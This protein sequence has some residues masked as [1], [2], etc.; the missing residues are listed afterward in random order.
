MHMSFAFA[1]SLGAP[2]SGQ[3]FRRTEL[4][5]SVLK[6]GKEPRVC[7]QERVRADETDATMTAAVR[8]RPRHLGL[9]AL[10]GR[11]SHRWRRTPVAPRIRVRATLRRDQVVHG[12]ALRDRS[13]AEPVQCSETKVPWIDSGPGCWS[14]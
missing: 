10:R 2:S 7:D 6:S 9:R 1:P 11:S 14:R 12:E 5:P 8:G 4:Q 13:S 3:L